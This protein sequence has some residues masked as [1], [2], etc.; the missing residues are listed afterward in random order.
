LE[1]RSAIQLPIEVTL[2]GEAPET[3]F[4]RTVDLEPGETT[5]FERIFSTPAASEVSVTLDGGETITRDSS[6]VSV[7]P[8]VYGLDAAAKPDLFA[9]YKRHVDAPEVTG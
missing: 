5:T 1:L 4:S 6:V 9:V 8:E 7:L 3:I 2:R